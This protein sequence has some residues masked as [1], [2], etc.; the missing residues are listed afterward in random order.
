MEIGY[1][2]I[3]IGVAIMGYTIYNIAKHFK[4]K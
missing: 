2:A 1:I 3:A 4:K